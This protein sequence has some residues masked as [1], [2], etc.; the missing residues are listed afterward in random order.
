MNRIDEKFNKLKAERRKA[1]IAFLTVGDPDMETS[2]QAIYTLQD[3]GADLIELGVP[4]SDPAADGPVIQRADERAL[5][6]GT[7]IFAALEL[8][9]KVRDNIKI[10]IV[11]SLYYNVIV[12]YGAEKFFADCHKAGIDGLI[13]PDLPF[14]ESGEIAEY[15]K[16]YGV[17][18]I[19]FI[20]PAS[21]SRIKN[22]S[23][24]AKGFLHC[25]LPFD[26]DSLQTLDKTAAMIKNCT[27]MPVC[28]VS[29][30][31]DNDYIIK[32]SQ[33]FDGVIISSDIVEAIAS[34]KNK[35]ERID[36]LRT[37]MRDLK[38]CV[39]IYE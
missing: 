5:A 36:N 24:Y 39:M 21:K 27:D 32:L 17:Y 4:F 14:E 20:S 9:V 33:H 13:I 34:G 16:K 11:F 30:R 12:Q 7:D 18:Q 38:S 26:A 22:I 6:N 23:Q 1:L 19:H 28:A 8:A 31:S 29:D 10:P 15:T 37:K 3:E 2:E 35:N 25:I